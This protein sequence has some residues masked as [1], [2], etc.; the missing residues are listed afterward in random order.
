MGKGCDIESIEIGWL[1]L[2]GLVSFSIE[3]RHAG[4]EGT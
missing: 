4:F 1:F 2:M 3:P